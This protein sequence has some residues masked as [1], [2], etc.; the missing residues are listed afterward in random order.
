MESPA[1]ALYELQEIDLTIQQHEQRLEVIAGALTDNEIVQTAQALVNQ[2]KA[3]LKPLESEM[4]DLDHQ[5]QSTRQKREQTETRLYSGSVS[6]PKEL[7]DMEHSITSLK[8]WQNELEDRELELMLEIET[9]QTDFNHAQHSLQKALQESENKNLDLLS[10]KDKLQSELKQLVEEHQEA[11]QTM[12]DKN[13]AIYEDMK[14]EK[15]NHPISVL[16]EEGFCSVCGVQQRSVIVQA[17]RRN[18]D[19]IRCE[20]CNRILVH[21]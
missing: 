11:T 19:L 4:R 6:N 14:L 12:S 18:E 20:N 7:Q 5:V 9:A 17:V 15:A 2:A 10:E 21:I 8:K 3:R 1:K 16:L 13:L